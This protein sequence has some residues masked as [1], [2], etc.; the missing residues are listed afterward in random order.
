MSDVNWALGEC[1]TCGGGIE[2]GIASYDE[3][4]AVAPMRCDDEENC[5]AVWEEIYRW[6]ETEIQ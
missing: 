6:C 2:G 4:F 5:G 3:S 1:P